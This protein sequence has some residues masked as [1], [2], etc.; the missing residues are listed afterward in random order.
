MNMSRSV[1]WFELFVCVQCVSGTVIRFDCVSYN[2]L[3]N[4]TISVN[5]I[6]KL[7][8]SSKVSNSIS[9]TLISVV[10]LWDLERI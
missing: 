5:E 4:V 7:F 3:V 6:L 9:T 10:P 1:F 8:W 2:V